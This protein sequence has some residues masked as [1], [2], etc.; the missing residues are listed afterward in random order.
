M[1]ASKLTPLALENL[2]RAAVVKRQTGQPWITSRHHA[3]RPS[4]AALHARGLLDRQATR[5]GRN[6]AD[7]SYRYRI[8]LAGV[9]TL[10]AALGMP[11]RDAA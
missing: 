9:D 5:L 3:D 1:A 4:L 8:T 11:P 6:S 7:N 2:R 10:R